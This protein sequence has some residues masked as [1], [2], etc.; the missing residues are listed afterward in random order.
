MSSKRYI[1]EFEVENIKDKSFQLGRQKMWDDSV[2]AVQ[3]EPDCSV[4]FTTKRVEIATLIRKLTYR[5]L[6]QIADELKKC[7]NVNEPFSTMAQSLDD[8]AHMVKDEVFL[9]EK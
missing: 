4:V 9:E 5:E 8:W 3:D 6:M 2:I 1:D 7:E